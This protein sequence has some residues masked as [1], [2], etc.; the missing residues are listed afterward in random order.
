ME[1]SQWFG[2]YAVILVTCAIKST[3][4][5]QS[6]VV[7]F[8]S[9][10]DGA[11]NPSDNEW[12]EF[13]NNITASM[14]MTA[15]LW[16]KVRHFN[17]NI[18]VML[19]SYCINPKNNEEMECLQMFLEGDE[20]TA[21]RNLIFKGYIPNHQLYAVFEVKLPLFQ[22][23]TWG[24]FC[25]SSSTI[26]GRNKLHYNGKLIGDRIINSSSARNIFHDSLKEQNAALIFGQEPDTLR[27]GYNKFQAF[28][29]DLT[30]F[31]IWSYI[32]NDTDI[33]DMSTCQ[34]WGKG[35][36]VSWEKGDI[37]RHNVSFKSL[38]STKSLCT[39]EKKYFIIP[40]KVL[41]SN[42]HDQCV[43]HGGKLVVPRSEE[44]SGEILNI[45]NK[46]KKQCDSH[47]KKHDELGPS[48]W[49]AATKFEGKWYEVGSDNTPSNILNYSNWE[50]PSLEGNKKCALLLSNGLWKQGGHECNYGALCAVCSIT[51]TPVFTLKGICIDG[52]IDYN[53]YM[54]LG[55]KHEIKFFEGYKLNNIIFNET[56]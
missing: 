19:W 28:I 31:N 39:L 44:E 8:Q 55:D 51:D 29:G 46:H 15:C 7:S 1:V 27:G 30:G 52:D 38:L 22:H 14:S 41:Y 2:I 37:Q 45:V 35:N 40:K 23:R 26:D 18:A 11:M 13:S 21:N 50:Y 24:H 9:E 48:V 20:S 56:Y 16:I 12:I 42:A 32:L 47:S 25:W 4:G 17:R 5:D 34:T 10:S 3:R 43:V 36:M 49:I 54:K 33:K 53:Y 6:F